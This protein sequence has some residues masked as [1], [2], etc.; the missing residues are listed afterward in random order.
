MAASIT[1]PE[2]GQRSA[3]VRARA[4]EEEGEAAALTAAGPAVVAPAAQ[5]SLIAGIGPGEGL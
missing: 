2:P 1:R 3:Q 5:A 4:E